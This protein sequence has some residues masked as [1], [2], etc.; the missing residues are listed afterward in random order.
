M[1][2]EPRV[3]LEDILTAAVKVEKYTQ[4]LSFDDF[5]DNDLISDAVIKNIL[6]IG[7][8]T[9]KFLMK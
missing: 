5:M 2:R 6:V 4:G 7:E 3:F 9:K 1:Q 8:A